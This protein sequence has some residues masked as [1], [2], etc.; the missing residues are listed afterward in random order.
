[1]PAF[2]SLRFHNTPLEELAEK[3]RFFRVFSEVCQKPRQGIYRC[4]TV[5]LANELNCKP[6]NIPRILYSIQHNG[7]EN[8]SYEVD[9]ESYFLRMTEIPNHSQTIPLA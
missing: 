3:D 5:T 9:K 6:Y 4:S 1:L 2:V 7:T 8:M